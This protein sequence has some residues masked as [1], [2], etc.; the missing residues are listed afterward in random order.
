MAALDAY[1]KWLADLKRWNNS[2][3]MSD[4]AIW[5]GQADA[6]AAELRQCRTALVEI[7]HKCPETWIED[8]ARKALR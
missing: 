2:P 8:V 7:A 5:R 3:R 1:D 4:I 6:L